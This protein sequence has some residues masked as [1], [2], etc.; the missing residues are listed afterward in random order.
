MSDEHMND[1]ELEAVLREWT[2]QMPAGQPDR[3]HVVGTIVSRLGPTRRRRHRRWPFPWFRRDGTNRASERSLAQ[4][5]SPIPAANGHTPT[6]MGRTQSMLSPAKAIIVAALVFAIGGVMLIAQPFQQRE[7]TVPGATTEAIRPSLGTSNGLIAFAAD[8]SA[9]DA[10]TDPVEFGMVEI[11]PER[12]DIY[13]TGPGE[14]TRRLIATDAHERCPAFSPDGQRLAYLEL[15]QRVGSVAP[16][17]VV[18]EVDAAGARSAPELRVPLPAADVYGVKRSIGTPCPQWS[19]DGS[20]IAYLAFPHRKLRV[21]TLDGQERVL[22]SITPSTSSFVEG[23]FAWSPNG[24]AIAYTTSD[25]VWVGSLDGSAPTLVRRTDG[26]PVSVSWSPGGELAVTVLTELALE[27]GGIRDVRTVHVV[28]VDTGSE[29]SVGTSHEYDYGAV[30]SPDGSRLAFVDEDGNVRS[31]DSSDGSMMTSSPRYADGREMHFWDVAWSPDG[32]R[33]LALARSDSSPSAA[34]SDSDVGFTLVSL[35]TDGASA[36]VLTP[37]TWA[38]D[39][40]NLQEVSW[41][42]ITN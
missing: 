34:A 17:I 40:I 23:P 35:S 13:A 25:G 2:P 4:Q 38:M 24:D 18:A 9:G 10:L 14:P 6:V 42:P 29:R 8:A 12:M 36:D 26:R 1:K 16:S 21:S 27:G 7:G 28:D 37:W 31:I 15:G 41:Q 22:D 20:Q 19:P 39:W 3:S 5:P 32:E 33:L 11:H 30:W